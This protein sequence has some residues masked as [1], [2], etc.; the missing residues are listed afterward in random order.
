[1]S[2]FGIARGSSMKGLQVDGVERRGEQNLAFLDF[3]MLGK[4]MRWL[5]SIL[6]YDVDIPFVFK[7][8]LPPRQTHLSRFKNLISANISFS[9]KGSRNPQCAQN[10]LQI[11][12]QIKCS[13]C[14]LYHNNI[15]EWD[16]ATL[17]KFI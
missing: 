10:S 17:L 2:A 6:L 1:M 11:T 7:F 9:F 16:D 8:P 12:H 14:F 5:L 3:L 4:D 15:E 13:A